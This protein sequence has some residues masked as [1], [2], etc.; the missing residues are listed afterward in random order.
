MTIAWFETDAANGVRSAIPQ[1]H[2]DH[3]DLHRAA[4]PQVLCGPDEAAATTDIDPTLR[5]PTIDRRLDLDHEDRLAI[6]IEGEHI[7]LHPCD[8]SISTQDPA[9]V[10][11][12]P[13]DRTLLSQSP[14]IAV[15]TGLDRSGS[16]E[17][18]SPAQPHCESTHRREPCRR[19][20]AV[21]GVEFDVIRH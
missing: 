7:D 4:T 21:G 1:V 20:H 15:R 18:E 2:R 5:R 9:A 6:L 12:K 11:S 19:G 8:P 10:R 3:L 14:P 13:F 17:Q 16:E